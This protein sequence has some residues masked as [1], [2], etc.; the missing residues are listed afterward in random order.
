MLRNDADC[1]SLIGRSYV[2]QNLIPM[3]YHSNNDLPEDV[4][5]GA[6]AYCVSPLSLILRCSGA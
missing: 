4:N 6:P 1:H 3:L 2:V 5:L